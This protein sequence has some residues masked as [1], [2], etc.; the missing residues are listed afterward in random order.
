[1]AP[2]VN[3]SQRVEAEPTASESLVCAAH[4]ERRAAAMCT[5]CGHPLCLRCH[6]ADAQGL[7]VCAACKAALAAAE[8][9]AA[10]ATSTHPS[11]AALALPFDGTGEA[12][13]AERVVDTVR[14]LTRAPTSFFA[15][16]RHSAEV[17]RALA[18]GYV[19]IAVGGVVAAGWQSLLE[20]PMV[21]VPEGWAEQGVE[22]LT[23]PMLLLLTP[24]AAGL[25]LAIG[26]VALHVMS[27][28]LGGRGGLRQTAQ[29]VAYASVANLL[30]FVPYVG[31][32]LALT[33]QL[34]L[35][36]KGIESVHE[37]SR[38]R[39]ILASLLPTAVLFLLLGGI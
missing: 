23:G 12:S 35:Q 22:P 19:C 5:R 7:A 4:P 20:L 39:A 24:L 29:V 33:A 27:R 10:A 18:F 2:P 6:G 13:F 21:E 37:L 30:L 8:A 25:Q 36:F 1:M 9:A 3:S 34:F 11:G 26:I 15:Q 32:L 28:V 17:V 38:G 31:G 16:L 14:W